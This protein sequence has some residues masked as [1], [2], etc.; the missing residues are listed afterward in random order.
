MWLAL[1][2]IDL[3]MG[4]MRFASGTHHSGFFPELPISYSSEE[5]F[6]RMIREHNTPIVSYSLKAGDATFHSGEVL[7]DAL[8]NTSARRRE[9][10]AIIYF[11]DGA[12]VMKPDHIH[13]QI[14]MEE[15]LPGLNPGDL[16]AGPL[17]PLVFVSGG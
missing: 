13:R 11:E 4:A 8:P 7:H 17:N 10:M 12:R 9:V 1:D 6:D 14:D 16:A 5:L 15:F 3:E 2:D